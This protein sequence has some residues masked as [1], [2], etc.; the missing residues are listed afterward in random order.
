VNLNEV[1]TIERRLIIFDC[2]TTGPNPREDRIVEFGF[3]ELKPDGTVREWQTYVNPGIPIPHEAT[4]GNPEKGYSGH[5]ITDAMVQGCSV[6]EQPKDHVDHFLPG[7]DTTVEGA[8]EFK[9]WP[10]FVD[11]AASLFKGLQDCDYCGFNIRTYDLPLVKA[12]FERSGYPQWSYTDARLVDGYR[13]WQLG[14]PRN[15]TAAVQKFLEESHDG[16]HRALDDVRAS[17]RVIA[18]MLQ[19]FTHLPRDVAQL[20]AMQ[21]PV[22]PNAV[23]PDGKILWKDG[24]AVMNFGKNWKGKPLDMMSKRDLEWIVSPKCEGASPEVKAV[25]RDALA[26]KFPVKEG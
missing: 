9:P 11:I 4:Y 26:G 19:A 7:C 13:L 10:R 15:L 21:F 14:E 23:T 25:C 2:E 5:G 24:V 3:F 16:A 22:D 20:H 17:A 8:H 12:E 6:C 18:G 1:L